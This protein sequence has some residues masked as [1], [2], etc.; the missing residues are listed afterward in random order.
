MAPRHWREFDDETPADEASG[1]RGSPDPAQASPEL[2]RLMEE[3]QALEARMHRLTGQPS[4]DEKR[5]APG[6]P[7]TP[8]AERRRA[9]EQWQERRQ[10]R[11]E[12]LRQRRAEVARALRDPRSGDDPDEGPAGDR[13]KRRE[14]GAARLRRKAKRA[15]EVLERLDERVD[16]GRRRILNANAQG[17]E[18]ERRRQLLT[19]VG[20]DLPGELEQRLD[21]STEVIATGRERLDKGADAWARARDRMRGFGDTAAMLARR[22]DR[23][24]GV[25]VG[26]VDELGARMARQRAAAAAR[27]QAE[28]ETERDD[29]NRRQRALARWRQKRQEETRGR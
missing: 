17:R 7:V 20:R 3:R 9:D 16:S 2:A 22:A 15:D 26:S 6:F 25:G 13:H 14:G 11:Q 10:Q 1:G 27:R 23:L 28:R 4:E 12:A 18:L 8:L 29:D 5:E 24:L 21:R 19:D